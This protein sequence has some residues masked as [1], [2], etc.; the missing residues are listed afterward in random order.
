MLYTAPVSA[1][2]GAQDED[3][4]YPPSIQRLFA[5]K[6]PFLYKKLLDYASEERKTT[7]VGPVSQWK[8]QIAAH[9]AELKLHEENASE[10]VLLRRLLRKKAHH[11]SLSRQ[12]REWNDPEILARN[13]RD[14]MKDPYRTVFISRLAYTLSELDVSKNFSKYGAIEGIRII[15][16]KTGQSRGYGFVVFERD[17]DAKNCIRELAPTG[18]KIALEGHQK[19]TVLVDMERGRLVRGWKPR[20]LAG[21]LGGRHYTKPS[22]YHSANASA[23]ASGRRLH[24]PSNPYQNSDHNGALRGHPSGSYGGFS[25]QN[26]RSAF[27]PRRAPNSTQPPPPESIRDKYA[28]YA[29]S[30]LSA[31]YKG[32]S[33][34]LGRSI[35]SIRLRE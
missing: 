3:D 18:L 29:S 1:V 12:M 31:E 16:D 25:A 10:N 9:V 15:R 17:A 28:K 13:E 20:R 4:K 5:P 21:G 35:R 30:S 19:R 23:A 8:T 24:L 2:L 34:N 11:E 22:S 32:A 7:S 14:F 27:P 26:E 6:P 33:S